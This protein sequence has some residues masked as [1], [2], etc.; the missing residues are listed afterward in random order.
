MDGDG[1]GYCWAGKSDERCLDRMEDDTPG[2]EGG[3][4]GD[5]IRRRYI[6]SWHPLEVDVIV[7]A[8]DAA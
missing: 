6:W 4:A 3:E 5:M 1:S 2:R 8:T 7:R